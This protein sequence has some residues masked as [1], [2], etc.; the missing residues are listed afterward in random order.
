VPLKTAA[1]TWR[2][3]EQPLVP[4]GS[5]IFISELNMKLRIND[6]AISDGPSK[7]DLYTGT[8]NNYDF[9]RPDGV[10]IWILL[11]E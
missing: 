3:G 9:E 4:V 2:E 8:L 1:T 11:E 6:V 5:T 10:D 7:I